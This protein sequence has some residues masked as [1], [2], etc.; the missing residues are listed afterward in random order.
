[1]AAEESIYN[2]IPKQA[3]KQ[4][5]K[6]LYK[7]KYPSNLT[8]TASTFGATATTSGRITN[9]DGLFN[10]K[11]TKSH[12]RPKGSFGPQGGRVKT[13]KPDMF[14]KKSTGPMSR[15]LPNR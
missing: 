2:V 6:P 4:K 12:I 10:W 14:L 1:M 13:E 9:M 11:P 15:T 7:S 5:K 8:P 3:A